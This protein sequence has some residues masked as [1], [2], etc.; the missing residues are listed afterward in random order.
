MQSSM[1]GDFDG[2]LVFVFRCCF[3]AWGQLI[4]SQKASV[5]GLTA[6]R[7]KIRD[8]MLKATCF[9]P[10]EEDGDL[11][12]AVLDAVR[13]G[14]AAKQLSAEDLFQHC[15]A[16]ADADSKSYWIAAA[17]SRRILAAQR[18]IL[19]IAGGEGKILRLKLQS[20]TTNG[21][22]VLCSGE[23]IRKIPVTVSSD[24]IM[25]SGLLV[26]SILHGRYLQ[27]CIDMHHLQA[28]N[29]SQ[30]LLVKS[31]CSSNLSK[32][33][34]CDGKPGVYSWLAGVSSWLAGVSS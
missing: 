11:K 27:S 34:I 24:D 13:N 17:E 14:M 6:S 8:K 18:N 4:T 2:D 25:Q 23:V 1:A 12:A 7:C 33:V 26:A 16:G 28:L 5:G 3:S 20:L 10:S 32:H 9:S 31:L 29:A 21:T 22:D 30:C 19:G 15:E